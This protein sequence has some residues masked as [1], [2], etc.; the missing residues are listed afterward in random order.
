MA[1]I[2]L[3]FLVGRSISISVSNITEKMHEQ[4]FSKF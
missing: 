3:F 1:K 2:L 4:D